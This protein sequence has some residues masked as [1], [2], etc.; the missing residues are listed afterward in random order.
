MACILKFPELL[1]ENEALGYNG[2]FLYWAI[3]ENVHPSWTT[4]N[5]VP[6][7]FRISEKCSGSLCTIPY[8]LIKNL[9]DFQN[10]ARLSMVFLEFQSKLTKFMEFQSG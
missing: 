5:G 1:F 10:F 6:K 8:L 3:P 7:N 2:G 4:V 9:G